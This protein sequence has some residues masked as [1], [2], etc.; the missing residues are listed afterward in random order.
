MWNLSLAQWRSLFGWSALVLFFGVLLATLFPFDFFPQN[1]VDVL[2]GGLAFGQH[3]VVQSE[4][5]LEP[6]ALEAD[7][8]CSIEILLRPFPNY[9]GTFLAFFSDVPGAQLR[10]QQYGNGIVI[11]RRMFSWSN[12]PQKRDI[13]QVFRPEDPLVFLTLTSAPNGTTVYANGQILRRL[14]TYVLPRRALHGRLVFGSDSSTLDPWS[15]ELRGLALY[16]EE[17]SASQVTD[18]Y[19]AWMSGAAMA[20]RS[21]QGENA[22]FTF[23]QETGHRIPNRCPGGASLLVPSGFRVP[24]KP[25]LAFPWREFTPDWSYA[26]DV[27]RNILG[28]APFGFALYGYLRLSG[29]THRALLVTVLAGACTSFGIEVLQAFIPQ[30]ESGLTD[31]MTNTFGMFCGALLLCFIVKRGNVQNIPEFFEANT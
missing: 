27:L 14:P 22:L 18:H 17:L 23:T 15:G 4:G 21:D 9:T 25:F 24:D 13:G 16:D 19:R 7:G 31:V 30:R 26:T 28:F 5:L 2:E 12:H 20:C 10:L 8:P 11:W 3:G 1:N 29:K 6:R